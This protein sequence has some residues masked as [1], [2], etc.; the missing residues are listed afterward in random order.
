MKFTLFIMIL[1]SFMIAIPSS[2]AGDII[3]VDPISGKVIRSI[4]PDNCVLDGPWKL[5]TVFPGA[6][7]DVY[8]LYSCGMDLDNDTYSDV[9]LIYAWDIKEKRAELIKAFT[10]HEFHNLLEYE[11]RQR[12]K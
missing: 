5:E 12:H 8:Q 1:L 10:L 9:V 6:A 11:T 3:E 4:C 2:Y 7:L